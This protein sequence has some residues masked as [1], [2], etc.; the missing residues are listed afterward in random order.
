MYVN[1]VHTER[2][3]TYWEFLE[4]CVSYDWQAS[5]FKLPPRT[6][7]VLIRHFWGFSSHLSGMA[8]IV[9]PTRTTEHMHYWQQRVW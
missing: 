5:A 7:H 8:R 6:Y 3:L 9:R 4:L 1:I 2:L